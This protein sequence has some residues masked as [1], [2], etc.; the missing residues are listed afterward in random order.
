[1]VKYR[2]FTR[3]KFAMVHGSCALYLVQIIN[4]NL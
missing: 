3:L 1:M 4:Y 2:N